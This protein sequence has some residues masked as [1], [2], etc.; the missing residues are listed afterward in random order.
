L[1][2][3]EQDL[4][5]QQYEVIVVDSSPD[6]AVRRT[7][8][9]L[10]ADAPCT[11]RLLTKPA[12]GPGPSRNLG[13]HH[14]RGEIIAFMDSD[15]RASP[16]WLRQGIAAFAD[17]VGVVQGRTLP[18][19]DVPLGIF[20]W[21]VR[22][23]HETFIY[24]GAN[25]FYRKAAI[26]QVGG[27]AP[28]YCS[29]AFN[30]MGGEDL[31]LAWRVKRAGWASRFCTEALVYHEVQPI[32]VTRWLFIKRHYIWPRL[33]SKFPELRP[34]LFARYF[35]DRH[36]ACLC[37]LLIGL[38]L[39]AWMPLALILCLPYA[40]SRGS[41]PTR[42][43]TGPLRLLRVLVYLPRDFLSLIIL[44]AGSLRYRSLLL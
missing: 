27:F 9:E 11:L 26:E 43:L 38:A 15:C 2:L 39:A 41:E 4:P 17:R 22:I 30:S 3:F 36:Q 35:F 25:I 32:P 16:Q 31:D 23:E 29:N 34:F 5:R 8:A 21:Y 14:A 40:I 6:D 42:T 18:E 1:S 24:E 19:P 10:Q 37:L 12:E 7:V 44:S 28:E 13:A 20:T 33:A